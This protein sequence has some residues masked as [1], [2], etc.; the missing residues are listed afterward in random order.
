MRSFLALSGIGLGVGILL[1]VISG[2]VARSFLVLLQVSYVPMTL[3]V[4][5]MMAGIVAVA[6]YLPAR[7]ATSIEPVVALK[8]E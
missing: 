2:M 1:A 6:A 8:H 4:T 3:G 5:G 7:R